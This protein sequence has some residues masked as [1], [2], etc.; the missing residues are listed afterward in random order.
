MEVVRVRQ[1]NA[2]DR[3]SKPGYCGEC[4]VHFGIHTTQANVFATPPPQSFTHYLCPNGA[5]IQNASVWHADAIIIFVGLHRTCRDGCGC[6]SSVVTGRPV[7]DSHTWIFPV[8]EP[9]TTYFASGVH[10]AC[11]S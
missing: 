7:A 8:S 2:G 4:F 1:T 6:P 10:G 9:E 3:E 5:G 11:T